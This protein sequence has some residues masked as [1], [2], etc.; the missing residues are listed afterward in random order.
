MISQLHNL[1]RQGFGVLKSNN[2]LLFVATLLFLFPLLFFYVTNSFIETA[3]KNI[4]TA[5]KRRI[6]VLHD[7]LAVLL[8]TYEG[9]P[10]LV[11]DFLS[12]QHQEMT[13]V[14][15][16]RVVKKT[17]DLYQIV[18]SFEDEKE[19]SY[20]SVT[21]IYTTVQPD[22]QNSLIYIF[23]SNPARTW[24]AVRAVS[25]NNST[26]YIL[27]E[28]SFAAVDSVM[29][30]RKQQ[31]Y[32]GLTAIFAFLIALAYWFGRQINW[33]KQYDLLK[34]QMKERDLFTNMIAHEFRTPLTAIRGYSSFLAESDSITTKEKTFVDAVQQS[35]ERLLALVNDFLEVARIQSGNMNL[36]MTT[37]DIQ[38][39]IISVI[40]ALQPIAKSKNLQLSFH[41]LA[42]PV[43]LKTDTKR[44]YQILQNLISNSLKYTK[45]GTVEVALDVTPRTVSIRIKDSGM[46]ISADDQ[47]K[48]FS[49][50]SR[51]GGV[52]QTKVVGTGL[53]MWITKQLVELLQG[54]ITVESIKDVGT[55]VIIVFRR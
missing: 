21:D 38:P 7:S 41:Q 34:V 10:I 54:S 4:E 25:I 45:D 31:A 49:P 43:A 32:L 22:A 50:F 12:L 9:N 8:T 47:Q 46:G 37:V 52:E 42:V 24:Q 36:E 16:I 1:M 53:G 26:Y 48:L 5:E 11:K 35:T 51:V 33:R 30:A 17:K 28:H 20:E 15:E 44:L 40:E 6:A 23:D 2:H 14:L 19:G 55:H 18:E 13:D 3:E 29:Q 39:T 27:S